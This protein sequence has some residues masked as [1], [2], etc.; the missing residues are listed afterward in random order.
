[1]ANVP[2]ADGAPTGVALPLVVALPVPAELIALI[3]NE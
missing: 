3:R 2:G 1:M